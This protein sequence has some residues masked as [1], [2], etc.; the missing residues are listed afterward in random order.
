MSA[1]ES[2][3][4]CLTGKIFR[5]VF[6]TSL[7]VLAFCL[8]FIVGI[9]TQMFEGQVTEELKS[10]AEFAAYAVEADREA[11]FSHGQK[12]GRRVTLIA[13]D[14]TVID[15]TEADASLMENHIER[16]EVKEA[17]ESGE[18][19][20]VRYSDTLTEKTVYY[21][22]LMPD[23]N[24]LRL[25]V[26]RY[27]AASVVL[28]LIYPMIAVIVLGAFISLFMSGR[29]AK[30]VV[31]PINEIDLEHPDRT[32]CYDELAPLL[33]RIDM[34][35]HTISEQIAKSE[36]AQRDFNIITENMSEGFLIIDDKTNLLSCNSAA[37]RL[38]GADGKKKNTGVLELNRTAQFR[39]TIA[40]VLSGKRCQ[41]TMELGEL[42]YSLIASPVSE[43]GQT[44][45]AVII[46]V[47]ITESAGR[48]KLR[49]EFTANVSHELKTPLTSISGFAEIMAAGGTPPE[50]VKDFSKSIYDEAQRL[51]SLVGDIIKISELDEGEGK[52]FTEVD[53]YDV[54][55][56][57][58]KRAMPLTDKNGVNITLSG[59]HAKVSGKEKILCEIAENIVDNAVKYNKKDGEVKVT[60]G[61]EGGTVFLRVEDTGIGIPLKDQK[62]VF[63]RF[64][65]VDKGRSKALGGTGLGLS[66]VK[67]AAMYHNAEIKLKSEEGKGTKIEILFPQA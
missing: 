37:L 41:S 16:K 50:T 19:Q 48:E 54:C 56:E 23:G 38:L 31:R 25:S 11:F 52:D 15:D 49:R 27:T 28:G 29:I 12:N 55:E 10:E 46:I 7:I 60:V 63:E 32:E 51:I 3:E 44:I 6:F 59:E 65:R 14:G 47:D 5:S 57:A 22:L 61:A 30:S 33:K 4:I 8:L 18:G 42:V 21:A 39:S 43:N 62:R 58:V 36:R 17:F 64:Y 2:E 9:L 1:T 40:R 26:K 45:G 34:Q 20:S 13:H 66:I 53:L 35:N 67:H 24:V